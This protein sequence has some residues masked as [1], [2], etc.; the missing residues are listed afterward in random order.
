MSDDL[1]L[2]ENLT[3]EEAYRA[4]FFMTD[5]YLAMETTPD[6]GLVLFHQYMQSDPAR[7]EDWEDAVREA[8]RPAGRNPLRENLRRD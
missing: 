4:A 2:P 3:L 7:W 5:M 6:E 8:L 1:P